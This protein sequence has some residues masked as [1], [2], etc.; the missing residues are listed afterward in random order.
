MMKSLLTG[1]ALLAL[2]ADPAPAAEPGTW[3]LL[4]LD[5]NMGAVHPRD[6]LPNLPTPVA[7]EGLPTF[8]TL[9]QC[10]RALRQSI[11]FYAY[12]GHVHATG[13][14]GLYLRTD[15]RTWAHE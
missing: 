15:Y 5:V 12:P 6:T 9:A 8:Q 11:R 10:Q 3:V 7:G 1:V 13:A 14:F 2:I 4:A